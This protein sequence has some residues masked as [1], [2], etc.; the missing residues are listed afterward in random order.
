MKK[1]KNKKVSNISPKQMVGTFLN[2]SPIQAKTIIEKHYIGLWIKTSG[3][4]E[5]IDVLFNCIT[6]NF[7]DNDGV[8]ISSN[9]LKPI[10][11]EVSVLNKKM[12]I[13]L[14]GKIFNIDESIVVLDHCELII[15]NEIKSYKNQEKI[16]SDTNIK[17]ATEDYEETRDVLAVSNKN[18]EWK[19]LVLKIIVGVLI[20][21]LGAGLVY[22]LGWN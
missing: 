16:L 13:S 4:I 2:N 5:D 6:L 10:S 15:D 8:F 21:V 19:K 1:E 9:F 12:K 3:V 14:V 11:S 7:Y 17:I 18:S 22:Y 20:I